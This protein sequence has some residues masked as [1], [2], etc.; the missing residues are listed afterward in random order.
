VST[1]KKEIKEAN[2]NYRESGFADLENR[3]HTLIFEILNMVEER[4]ALKVRKKR[5]KELGLS[6]EKGL[7]ARTLSQLKESGMT[8]DQV[9]EILPKVCV[10]PVLTAHPTEAKRPTVRERHLAIYN[11]LANWDW[12][13]DDKSAI[14]EVLNSL[15]V[16]LETLWFTGEIHAERPSLLNELRHAIYY[17]REV[18]PTVIKKNDAAL[19]AAW[20]AN[21]WSL[22]N[23]RQPNTY[24]TLKFGSWIGG[25]RDGHPG[26][27]SAVTKDT[28]ARLRKHALRIHERE[29]RQAAYTLTL[30]PSPDTIPAALAERI[31][32]L[33]TDLPPNISSEVLRRNPNVPWRQFC[34]LIREKLISKK[35]GYSSVDDY[36]ADLQVLND[37]LI[38]FGAEST[39]RKVVN[40][41]LRLLKV[42]GFHL[43]ELDI[44]QNSEFHDAACSQMLT[45]LG[46]D[47]GSSFAD[48]PEQE[49]VDFLLKELSTE[50][51][52]REWRSLVEEDSE[53][54]QLM[55]CLS[56]IKGSTDRDGFTS[57]GIYII[58]MARQLSDLLL[59]HLFSREGGLAQWTGS[60]WVSKIPVCPLF[61]TGEDLDNASGIISS[62]LELPSS[63]DF[64]RRDLHG[65][66]HMPIMVGY[67]DSTKDSGILSG[68][69]SLQKALTNV[70]NV[71]LKHKTT[72]EFFHGRGGTISRG[73][74]PTSAFLNALPAGSLGGA[75]R[76][77]EQGEVVPRKYSH[78]ASA[79]YN[80][81]LLVAGA[82]GVTAKNH[83]GKNNQLSP[84]AIAIMDRLAKSSRA[85]YRSLLE[86]DRFLTPL[87]PHRSLHPQRPSCHPL[88]LL[89]DTGT[90]LHPRMVWSRS[91]SR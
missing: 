58:S 14:N 60:Q 35:N 75:I 73:A 64:L 30:S 66:T 2:A 69:W 88:G 78:H 18:F 53:A 16:N 81:E 10:T 19:E 51:P 39:A 44:R 89:M 37:P 6:A 84:E 24:P 7:W 62:Y 79:A 11:D 76:V 33:S 34:H 22:K 50:R 38:E 42:F 28:L 23:L 55:D 77:T 27:T 13:G 72:G 9:L 17:L 47:K 48:W 90:L 83:S 59:V 86:K 3:L 36:R 70:T 80:L 29:I 26:V 87:S 85:Q 56:V 5:T 21:G 1:T 25:D 12:A 40:P 32:S 54:A 68:Q 20:K 71:C 67:S 15:K 91:G 4:T 65:N 52:W 41:L 74:G 43:A 45:A 49:R 46:I 82:A 8:E 63:T 31:E 61:E 57:F